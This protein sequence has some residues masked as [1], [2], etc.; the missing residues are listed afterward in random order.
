MLYEDYFGLRGVAR[1]AA[2]VVGMDG[3]IAYAWVSERDDVLPDF[4]GVRTATRD[5]PSAEDSSGPAFGVSFRSLHGRVEL[6]RKSHAL[7]EPLSPGVPALRKLAGGV[8]AGCGG[9][10]RVRRTGGERLG[11]SG[12]RV[13]ITILGTTDVHGQIV[14]WDYYTA[15]RRGPGAGAGR[16]AG[17]LHPRPAPA[18]ILVDSG[19][20]LQGNPFDYYYGVVEPAGTHPVIAAM[21]LLGYDAAAV[22]NHEFNFGIPALERAIASAEFPFLAAN[23]FVAGTDSTAFPP[24]TVVERGGR[25]GRDPGPDDAGLGDL[26]PRERR[27]QARV[28][29][30]RRVGAGASGRSSSARAT[31]RSRSC[32][33]VSGPGSSYDEAA[34]GVPPEDAG[35]ALAEALPGLEAMFLGHSHRSSP[36]RPLRACSSRR[37]AAGGRRSRSYR[38]GLEL[39]GEGW[40]VVDRSATAIPTAG[41]PPKPALMAEMRPFHEPSSRTWPTR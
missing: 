3:R 18:V 28:P 41:V 35:G 25:A 19:D 17:G 26:G 37:P 40:R 2:F 32:T 24:Y 23:V 8:R 27:G 6:A 22:G 29:R 14:P 33:R 4:D 39:C 7:H 16:D 13:E 31:S 36:P 1:R 9:R 12:D 5:A 34:T 11:G 20:L 15:V 21:N 10:L 30:H 38:S